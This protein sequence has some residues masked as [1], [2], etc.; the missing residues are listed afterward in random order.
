MRGTR[1]QIAILVDDMI[2]TGH[3]VRL[4]AEVL[5]EA[6]AKEIYV[7]ISHGQL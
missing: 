3:T 7:L 5:R 1:L 2:D 4:A 6:G